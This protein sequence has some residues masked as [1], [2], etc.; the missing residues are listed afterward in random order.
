MDKDSY[1]GFMALQT[2]PIVESLANI[3]EIPKRKALD[4]FYCSEFY[5]LYE[6]EETKLWHFSNVTL[7]DIINREISL[8][9]I[10]IPVEG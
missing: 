6:R 4:L 3:K 7:T 9:H 1:M 8:G 5:R 2:H 10:E